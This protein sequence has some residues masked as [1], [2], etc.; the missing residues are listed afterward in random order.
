[1]G[2]VNGPQPMGCKEGNISHGTQ[3]I[4]RVRAWNS[5]GPYSTGGSLI[6]SLETA[7]AMSHTVE[8]H[9]SKVQRV[10]TMVETMVEVLV[11]GFVVSQP[12]IVIF[13]T[14]RSQSVQMSSM[15]MVP[16]E[17][18]MFSLGR[19]S[20]SSH[21]WAKIS[22]QGLKLGLDLFVML[23]VLMMGL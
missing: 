9:S 16:Y 15:G 2:H 20:F 6:T 18:L 10:T 1:M 12:P 4:W 22:L 3:P 7:L 21:M 19:R 17:T 14:P 13:P 23:R 11:R 8:N 5:Q